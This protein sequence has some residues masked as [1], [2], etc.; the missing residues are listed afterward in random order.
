MRR[1]RITFPLLL[2]AAALPLPA[3]RAFEPDS[4]LLVVRAGQPPVRT[5]FAT[6]RWHTYHLTVT[7]LISYDGSDGFADCGHFDPEGEAPW[8][9]IGTLLLDGAG[10]Y[11]MVMPY[12]PVHTYSWDQSG[13]GAPY[14][15][16]IDAFAG[17]D[18]GAL[19]VAVSQ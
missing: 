17:D 1:L 2:L 15:F 5:P 18:V 12:S 16:A 7:G 8:G 13:T 4:A 11:C 19:V 3:A 6:Q 9:A 14:T 10:A